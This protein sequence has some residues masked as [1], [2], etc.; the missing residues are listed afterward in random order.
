MNQ[1]EHAF[2][3]PYGNNVQCAGCGVVF[4]HS[5]AV[6]LDAYR[7]HH[8]ACFHDTVIGRGNIGE[9]M[10]CGKQFL[11]IAIGQEISRQKRQAF[12]ELRDN[13]QHTEVV[14]VATWQECKTCKLTFHTDRALGAAR[15]LAKEKKIKRFL[16]SLSD[17]QLTTLASN[18]GVIL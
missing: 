18:M 15:Q 12:A 16:L 11:T 3:K 1:C 8:E 7:P 9:C 5:L 14:T 6:G 4:A 10:T 13:C 2:T 17:S